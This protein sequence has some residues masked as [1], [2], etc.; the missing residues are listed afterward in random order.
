MFDQMAVNICLESVSAGFG[1]LDQNTQGALAI[2]QDGHILLLKQWYVRRDD[3]DAWLNQDEIT[4][5]GGGDA[6]RIAQ[7]GRARKGPDRPFFLVADLSTADGTIQDQTMRAYGWH[8]KSQE[9]F[10]PYSSG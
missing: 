9:K 10:G 4:Q 1:W 8:R 3:V 7:K 2:G 5:L 6:I